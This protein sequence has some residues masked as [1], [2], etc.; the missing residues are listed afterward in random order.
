MPFLGDCAVRHMGAVI[1]AFERDFPALD[2]K[3]TTMPVVPPGARR[4]TMNINSIHG[5]QTDDFRPACLRPMC[6]TG[7]G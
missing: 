5:G 7:A 2:A 4:S 1:E 6:R 3:R